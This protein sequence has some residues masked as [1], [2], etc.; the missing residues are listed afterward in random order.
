MTIAAVVYV[1]WTHSMKAAPSFGLE[2]E[3][4]SYHVIRPKT[5]FPVMTNGEAIEC[6]EPEGERPKV[7]R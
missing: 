3:S 7:A 1:Q 2:E 6:P 5:W 4:R